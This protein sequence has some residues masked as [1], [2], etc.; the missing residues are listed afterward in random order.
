MKTYKVNLVFRN[1]TPARQEL[2]E[3]INPRQAK[4]F[5]ESRYPNGEATSA[6]EIY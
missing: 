3:A 1:G 2:I 4:D 5:A 6:N